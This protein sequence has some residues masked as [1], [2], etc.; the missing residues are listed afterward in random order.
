VRHLVKNLDDKFEGKTI[1]KSIVMFTDLNCGINKNIVWPF[2]S[3]KPS[4]R[5]NI[6]IL[7]KV[8]AVTS[9]KHSEHDTEPACF[10]ICVLLE[11]LR[12]RKLHCTPWSTRTRSTDA[13][14]V[15]F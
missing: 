13:M 2:E 10:V 15:R 7:I 12:H 8:M 6:I 1:L 14:C 5:P 11:R 9:G 4:P 3:H